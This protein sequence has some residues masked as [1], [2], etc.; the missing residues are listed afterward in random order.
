MPSSASVSLSPCAVVMSM[1][2]LLLLRFE[3]RSSL[4][5]WIESGPHNGDRRGKHLDAAIGHGGV[6]STLRAA[7]GIHVKCHVAVQAL[8]LT[9]VGGKREREHSDAVLLGASACGPLDRCCV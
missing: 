5:L 6:W 2:S 4:R 8:R 1:V 7:V 9:D 3:L